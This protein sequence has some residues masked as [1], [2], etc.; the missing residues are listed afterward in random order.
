MKMLATLSALCLLTLSTQ[1]TASG[2]HGHGEDDHDAHEQ[3]TTGPNGGHLLKE[4]D[5]VVEV[6]KTEKG[7]LASLQ[8]WVTRGNQPVDDLTLSATLTRLD[9]VQKTLAFQQDDHHWKGKQKIQPPHSFDVSFELTLDGKHYQWQWPS[10]EGRVVISADAAEQAGITTEKASGGVIATQAH[11]Y[12][13]LAIPPEYQADLRARFPGLITS[14]NVSVGDT[15]SKG[16]T[17]AVIE[18]ND[19]LRAYRLRAPFSGV[20]HQRHANAGEV[21]GQQPLLTLIN[22][23]TLW[24]ELT[25]F[26]QQRDAVEKGQT[27]TLHRGDRQWQSQIQSLIPAPDNGTVA[28]MI[29]RASL[30]NSDGRLASGDLVE[31]N[32]TTGNHSVPLRV[33]NRALQEMEGKTVVFLNGAEA[34]E[35]RELSLGRRDNRYSEVLDGLKP[36]DQY[37]VENSYLIKADILKAGAAHHH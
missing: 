34:Y 26:P 15:V 31:A 14:I 12:G 21:A 19:S 10:Y 32:I 3:E 4:Q 23:Q 13:R 24:A 27:V 8:A 17:L 6:L 36:G 29:A 35:S 28:A 1:V 18:S 25:L 37:V 9:G 20:I 30:D 11:A 16:D 5:V 22:S 33:D 7:G 2:D